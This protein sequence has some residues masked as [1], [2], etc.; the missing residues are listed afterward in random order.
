M[1]NDASYA[2]R[3]KFHERLY[4]ANREAAMFFHQTLL[5]PKGEKARAY[6]K[7]RG[8][9][10]KT[11]VRFGLGYAPDEWDALKKHLSEKKILAKDMSAAWLV[12]EKDGKSYDM[13]RNRVMFPIINTYGNV[14]AFGGRVLDDSTPKY[15]NSSDTPV[16]NKRKNLY[17]MNLLKQ[18]RGLKAA[19]LL[20][21]YM[22]VISVSAA[23]VP[24]AVA[25]LGTSFTKEQAH[26]LKRFVNNVYL[27]YDGDSA[28]QNAAL[29]AAGIL[30]EAGLNVRVIS[31]ED[32]MDP[33]DF[34]RK[35]GLK[36][37]TQKMK[38]SS[39]P[40]DFELNLLKQGYDLKTE[41]GRSDYLVEGCKILEKEKSPVK[42]ERYIKRL[43]E[44]TGYSVDAIARQSGAFSTNEN[45]DGNI[46]YTNIHKRE[47]TEKNTDDRLEVGL[48]K[49]ILNHPEVYDHI[50]NEIKSEYF[51]DELLK[52]VFLEVIERTKKGVLPTYAELITTLTN[53]DEIKRC[54]ALFLSDEQEI[55]DETYAV[56]C[57]HKLKIA[58]LLRKRED[59]V[60]RLEKKKEMDGD[61]VRELSRLDREIYL[62]RTKN[63]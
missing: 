36:G 48:M 38:T 50:K 60:L 56:N 30:E 33:D 61:L 6:L 26:L 40:I 45:S 58:S 28:G 23:G 2:E 8:I 9:D 59:M 52:K 12:K 4:L 25:S 11:I 55:Y 21:G 34:V 37:M 3:R 49:C 5:S 7:K 63:T 35:F 39:T 16:F 29:R 18:Q 24:G 42:R 17:A 32:G 47:L 44:E 22:D 53:E 27:S 54:S 10:H 19:L 57:I 41:D 43:S 13:F 51:T 31:Y 1:E 20:E 46:R 62:E 15:L 14:I